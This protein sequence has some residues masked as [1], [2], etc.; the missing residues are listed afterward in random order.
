M[1][2]QLP[3]LPRLRTVRI[4]RALSQAELAQRSGVSR[5]SITRLEGG[6]VDARF[7]TI[8][9]LA[10]ALGVDPR[11]LMAADEPAA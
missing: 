2:T 7:A 4:G 10:E 9:K 11:D 1:L 3:S 5:V 6:A 8:R